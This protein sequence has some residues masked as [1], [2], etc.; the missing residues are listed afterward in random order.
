MKVQ[1]PAVFD[2]LDWKLQPN[3]IPARW[4]V[5]YGGRDGAKSWTFGR[6]LLIAGAQHP[7][8]ILCARESQ[9]TIRDSVHH[10]LETQIEAM[11]LG[12][13]YEVQ[14]ATVKGREGTAAFG[15]EF[16]FEGLRFNVEKIK[17]YEGVDRCWVEEARSV[18]KTSW[19]T[20]ENTIRKAGSEIWVSFN[21]ELKTDETYKRFVITPPE[22]AV[23][24]KVLWKDNPWASE[25]LRRGRE[26]LQREDPDSFDHIWM[27]ACKETLDGAVY[28]KELRAATEAGRICKVPYDRTKPV[29]TFWDLGKRDHTSVWFAQFIA[30]QYRIMDFFQMRGGDVPEFSQMLV[31]KKYNYGTHFLPHDAAH[32]RLGMRNKSIAR[33]FRDLEHKVIVLPIIDVATGISQ[34]R[35]IFSNCYFD[36]EKTSEGIDA[37]RHYCYEVDPDTGQYGKMPLHDE[38][39]D[40]AD[41]FRYL[42][43]ALKD[44]PKKPKAPVVTQPKVYDYTESGSGWM[45]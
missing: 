16:I 38:N 3:G 39:S 18:S 36:E 23:V 4:K 1:F 29:D 35:A 15:T 37:L 13:F 19:V 5:A 41:A 9:K 33:Q 17:S 10:L 31:D 27:G 28:A 11:G 45:R 21:P 32:V 12:R 44:S 20:L 42:A 30:F 25:T 43:M 26:R 6:K 14:E 40:A 24:R 8:R 7:L 2:F 34:V 22:D